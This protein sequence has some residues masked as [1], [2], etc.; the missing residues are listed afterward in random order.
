MERGQRRRYKVGGAYL[1][2]HVG[3]KVVPVAH[4]A[5]ELWPR[6]AFLKRPGTITVSIGPAFDATGLSEQEINQR[7]EAWIEGEM[8]RISPHRYPETG[9]AALNLSPAAS[10]WPTGKSPTCCAAA[11][12]AAWDSASIT[13]A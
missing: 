10:G 12:G 7:A 6:Q 2:N 1:A 9:G 3:C 13:A 5:G 11:T 4:D 8:R